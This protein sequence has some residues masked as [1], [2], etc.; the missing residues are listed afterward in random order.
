MYFS[1]LKDVLY[2]QFFVTPP[3]PVTDFANQTIIVTGANTG[4]GLEAAKHFARLNASKVIIAV[5]NL[6]KG[7]AAKEA[8]ENETG[9]KGVIEVWQLDLS[10]FQ[11]VKDFAAQVSKLGRLDAVVENA[12]IGPTK[13]VITEGLES[14]ITT[15][16]ISTELLALLVLPKLQETATKFNVQPRLSIVTSEMHII[17]KFPERVSEDIFAELSR[18]DNPSFGERYSSFLPPSY[19]IS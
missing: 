8:I 11:S 16:V 6:D 2:S 5:R 1:F 3:Y 9:R 14:A 7:A 12:G 19:H 15:N 10:S 17:V 4:L 13:R 18:E